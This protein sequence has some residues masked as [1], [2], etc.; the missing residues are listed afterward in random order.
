MCGIAGFS[1][2]DCGRPRAIVHRGPDEQDV[3]ESQNISWEPVQ[4]KIVQLAAGKQP[5][6]TENGNTILVSTARFKI[7]RSQGGN[8]NRPYMP[9]TTAVVRKWF[10]VSPGPGTLKVSGGKQRELLPALKGLRWSNAAGSCAYEGLQK[11]EHTSK[12]QCE[13]R[14]ALLV[15]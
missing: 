13:P 11:R 5:M 9:S 1:H 8:S 6:G 3:N 12:S 15:E 10:C 14:V 7:I 4:F 2:R